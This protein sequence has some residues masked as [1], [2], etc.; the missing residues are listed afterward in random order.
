MHDLMSKLTKSEISLDHVNLKMKIGIVKDQVS[1][2][3][4]QKIINDVIN[5][6]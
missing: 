5:W 3:M 4:V 2:N 1:N 6:Y